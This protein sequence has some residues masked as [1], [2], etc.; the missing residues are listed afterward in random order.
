M[1]TASADL[2]DTHDLS[3]SGGEGIGT[4]DVLQLLAHIDQRHIAV[5]ADDGAEHRTAPT[6]DRTVTVT[7]E[8]NGD[9]DLAITDGDRV[10]VVMLDQ[11]E[12]PDR[13]LLTSAARRAGLLGPEQTARRPAH[14]R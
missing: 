11:L 14:D 9:T 3:P 7:R 13:Q 4:A 8:A 10:N 5:E 2:T 6:G 1:V 12:G